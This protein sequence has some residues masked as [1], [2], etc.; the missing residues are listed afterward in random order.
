MGEE[1]RARGGDGK[2][3]ERIRVDNDGA[4]ETVSVSTRKEQER[5][6]KGTDGKGEGVH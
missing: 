5:G 2:R 1:T 3:G 6:R 4:F